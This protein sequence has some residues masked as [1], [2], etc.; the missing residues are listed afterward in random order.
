MGHAIVLEAIDPPWVL[1]V[2]CATVET[3]HAP[4]VSM[5]AITAGAIF[6]KQFV[7]FVPLVAFFAGFTTRLTA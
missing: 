5:E 3:V 2:L 6:L 7:I 4:R 1:A